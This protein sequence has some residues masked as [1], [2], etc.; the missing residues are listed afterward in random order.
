MSAGAVLNA[1]T[2]VSD[3]VEIDAPQG[4]VWTV[5]VDYA[6]YPDWNPYT[7][8]VDTVLELGADVVL[9][10][11]DPARPGGSFTTLEHMRVIDAPYHLQY[12]TGDSFPGMLAVRDQWVED[13]GDGRSSY[14]TT[15][16]FTGDIAEAVFAMQKDWVT[17][18]FNATAYALKAQAE[19]LWSGR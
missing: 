14:R 9:H 15:D 2:I 10:L 3:T 16:V 6:R 5:L 4:F 11:P 8:R 18:G 12:D 19:R 1:T 17:D 13:L 7:F